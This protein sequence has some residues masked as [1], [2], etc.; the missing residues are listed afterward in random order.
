M[1]KYT[2]FSENPHSHYLN[3]ELR[4]TPSEKELS[5][6]KI[7]SWRP[8][9]YELGNFAKNVKNF[10][11]CNEKNV[12]LNFRKTAKDTW[13]ITNA[14]SNEI[15]L[16]YEYY[17]AELNAGSTF[18]DE[19]Q[20]YVNPVNC[21][22]FLPEQMEE[23][24]QLRLCIPEDF[25]IASSL[26]FQ[27]SIFTAKN[28]D[29]LADSPFIASAEL[30]STRF[31]SENVNFYL[32]FNGECNPDIER[33]VNDFKLFCKEC[34]RFFGK[35]HVQDYH[36]L[37]QIL[38]NHFYH[39]VEHL[40]NTVIAIGPAYHLMN[41]YLYPEVLGVSCHELFHTW[42]IKAIRPKEMLP[43]DF[44][45]ENYARTGF[46]YEGFTTY[47]GDKLLFSSGVF[48][49][50]TYFGT[51]EERLLKHFHNYGRFNLSVA[52]SSF[53]TW[54][55]GY[56]PGAPYRKTSIYDE[57]CLTAF[58][59]DVLILKSSGNRNNLQDLLKVLYHEFYLNG[60][61]Y[62]EHDIQSI[63]HQL[64]GT[65]LDYFFENYVYG[66]ENYEPLLTDCFQYLGLL[67]IKSS[68]PKLSERVFGIKTILNNGIVTV[69]VVAPESPAW[70]AGIF[71]GDEILSINA[72][73]VKNNLEE[74][75]NYFLNKNENIEVI[76]SKSGSL[77]SLKLKVKDEIDFY[78]IYKISK[79]P[80]LTP[81]NYLTWQKVK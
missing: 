76:V 78:P 77:R 25:K 27:D 55:D 17:A 18:V 14:G 68:N 71:N 2:L 28:F 11:A 35:I 42:N 22:I 57:G 31:E 10:R 66:K 69:S 65:D 56:V 46:V 40:R 34:I 74:W 24:H 51:L 21:C 61:G 9:R 23:I 26:P 44:T 79:D 62:S 70:K 49:E 75:L 59:L 50:K 52:D 32:H 47:Y 8:G 63:A 81:E 15:I 6:V 29:E 5:I 54:L 16:K 67:L 60:K 80:T 33:I 7:P 39:G 3:I 41:H 12:S 72:M 38:P 48:D 53:D 64:A 4:F 37:F 43:Y 1:I 19:K 45:K 58:M 20:I 13:E 36:F 73:Q 30:K